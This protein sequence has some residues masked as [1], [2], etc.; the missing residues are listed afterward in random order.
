[1]FGPFFFGVEHGRC[2][3]P[4]NG[5]RYL[6]FLQVPLGDFPIDLPAAHGIL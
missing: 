5:F 2:L 6:S 4:G 1:V 3:L